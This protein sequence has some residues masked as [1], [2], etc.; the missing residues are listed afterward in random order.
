VDILGII[1][2]IVGILI[3]VVAFL[4]RRYF[5][6]PELTI[7]IIK[8]G[9]TNVIVGLSNK[10]KI[11]KANVDFNNAIYISNITWQF[12]LVIRNNSENIAYYPKLI[13]DTTNPKFTKLENLNELIPISIKETI[14]LKAEYTKYE[15]CHAE[16]RSDV[17]N[18]PEELKNMKILLEYK[19][20]SKIKSYTLYSFSDEVKNI[21]PIRR[22]EIFI[23]Q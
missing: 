15:E 18:F 5:A 7:E 22:P 14:E 9:G 3:P 11:S 21:F 10:N 2:I 8:G 4:W 16:D 19:N 12:K 13:L 1:S 20:S 6:R 23:G 17:A